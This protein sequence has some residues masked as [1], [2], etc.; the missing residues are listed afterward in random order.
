LK[1]L[2]PVTVRTAY[3]GGCS[4]TTPK[5]KITSEYG[6]ILGSRVIVS[7]KFYSAGRLDRTKYRLVLKGSQGFATESSPLETRRLR[8]DT[9]SRSL[10]ISNPRRTI[11]AIQIVMDRTGG[12]RHH[13]NSHDAQELAKAEQR[14][15]ELTKVGF[16]A[17]V[18]I[19]KVR[20]ARS[21]CSSRTRKRSSS[22]PSWLAGSRPSRHVWLSTVV[23]RCRLPQA[24]DASPL[25]QA[26]R[27]GHAGGPVAAAI[28][29]MA[30]VEPAGAVRQ[31]AV[32]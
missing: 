25:H 26:R 14:F 18:R 30:V 3:P 1:S 17:A 19:V 13:F 7:G 29:K 4:E 32:L 2:R 5:Q 24:S 27:R 21:D 15:Y 6:S 28:A 31:T 23:A 20:S 22:C 12:G 16:A 8:P 10:A 11:M 9:G